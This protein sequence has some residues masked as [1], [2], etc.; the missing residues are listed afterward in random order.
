MYEK[1]SVEL[2]V[3]QLLNLLKPQMLQK[4]SNLIFFL[5]NGQCHFFSGFSEN[6]KRGGQRHEEMIQAKRNQFC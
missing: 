6:T 5:N 4:K 1:A 3:S 2:Q